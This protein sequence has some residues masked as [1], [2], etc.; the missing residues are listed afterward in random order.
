MKNMTFGA[1]DAE[2]KIIMFKIDYYDR[3]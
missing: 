3:T 1:F 2:G